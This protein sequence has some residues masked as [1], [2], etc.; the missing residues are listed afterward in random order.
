MPGSM[1]SRPIGSCE[2]DSPAGFVNNFHSIGGERELDFINMKEGCLTFEL[3]FLV[4]VFHHEI[5]VLEVVDLVPHLLI[6]YKINLNSIYSKYHLFYLLCSFFYP[7]SLNF[8]PFNIISIFIMVSFQILHFL[9]DFYPLL[10]HNKKL[11][12]NKRGKI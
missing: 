3:F 6:Q 10:Y 7:S 8:S 5:F 4:V 11:F 9:R 2:F 1:S 12:Q